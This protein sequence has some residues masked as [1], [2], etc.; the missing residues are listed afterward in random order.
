MYG[1]L[2]T[3][4]KAVK[5]NLYQVVLENRKG[6]GGNGV[7]FYWIGLL[8]WLL[9]GIGFL[10]FLLGLWRKSWKTL[11]ISGLLFL[12]PSLYFIGAENWLRL[13]VIIPILPFLFAYCVKKNM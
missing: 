12:V 3:A 9:F 6:K 13:L 7:D 4:K 10:L 5:I 1:A 8:Y 11:L 2:I